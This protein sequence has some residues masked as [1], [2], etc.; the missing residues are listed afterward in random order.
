MTSM[1]SSPGAEHFQE[2][3]TSL[4]SL[5]QG[6]REAEAMRLEDGDLR[7][8]HLMTEEDVEISAPWKVEKGIASI[9]DGIKELY[10]T[11]LF[12]IQGQ[13]LKYEEL[14]DLNSD[15]GTVRMI[16]MHRDTKGTFLLTLGEFPHCEV[17]TQPGEL[18]ALQLKED[19]RSRSLVNG[20]MVVN[21]PSREMVSEDIRGTHFSPGRPSLSYLFYLATNGD[22]RI[23]GL[24]F[25]EGK[26]DKYRVDL[27]NGTV[28]SVL[29]DTIQTER[30][31]GSSDLAIISDRFRPLQE[32]AK[33]VL[34]ETRGGED[35]R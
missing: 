1:Q 20:E 17:V 7:L 8:L 2:K 6:Y 16:N 4:G 18:L 35:L 29:D 22:G 23:A 33:G 32:W 11:L 24:E 14:S 25:S 9:R 30:R 5:T 19:T 3:E 10:D 26:G 28:T 27:D 31:L 34:K 13:T 15:R 21:S 12:R